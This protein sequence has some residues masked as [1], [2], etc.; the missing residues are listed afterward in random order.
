[1]T[2]DSKMTVIHL[3]CVSKHL[4]KYLGSRGSPGEYFLI[5]CF[6]GDAFV[7]FS[8]PL[9][10]TVLQCGARLQMYTL[11]KLLDRVVN[12]ASFLTGGV[13]EC[14]IEHRRSAGVLCVL[15]KVRCNPLHPLYGVIPVPYVPVR[16]TRG[17]LVEHR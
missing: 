2:L 14:D 4:L 5:D 10:S 3:R 12:G 1:M 16:V 13:F 9:L 7:V 11:I 17:A 15:Y 8:C 6:F